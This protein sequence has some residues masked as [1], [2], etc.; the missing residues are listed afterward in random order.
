MH[1][2]T[3]KEKERKGKKI[4]NCQLYQHSLHQN[5]KGREGGGRTI[6]LC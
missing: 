3:Y 2:S 5:K 4:T 6:I 1:V